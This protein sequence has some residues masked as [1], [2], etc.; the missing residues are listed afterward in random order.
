MDH[1]PD[2]AADISSSTQNKSKP[3]TK[4]C[5][6]EMTGWRGLAG[7]RGNCLHICGERME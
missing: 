7:P 3:V 1:P 6:G 5:R 2:E 4:L